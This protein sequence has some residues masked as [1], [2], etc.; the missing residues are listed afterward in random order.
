MG[1]LDAGTW[2]LQF[3]RRLFVWENQQLME[4]LRISQLENQ[5]LEVNYDRYLTQKFTNRIFGLPH[6]DGEGIL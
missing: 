1:D 6:G 4:N 2:E 5:Q 3:R